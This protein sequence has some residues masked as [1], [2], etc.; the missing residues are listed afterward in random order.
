MKNSNTESTLFYSISN[1]EDFDAI[2][3]VGKGLASTQRVR[4]LKALSRRPM[5]LLELSILLNMPISSISFN[6][7]ILEEAKLIKI[8]YK[9]A[10]KGKMKLCSLMAT[11]VHIQTQK[12]E[13]N[14]NQP[15]VVEMPVGCYT[16]ADVTEAYLVGEE[17]FIFRST[18]GNRMLFTPNRFTGQLFSFAEGSVVYD[19]PNLCE[20]TSKPIVISFSMEFC[21]EAPYYR[22]D[23]PSDITIW[24][25]DVEIAT[26]TSPGDFGG[27]RGTYTPLFWLT[28]STQ[29]GLLY[30]FS[31]DSKG[32]Y[33]NGQ[34]IFNNVTIKDLHLENN[35]SIQLKIGIKDDAIH[36]GGI[37]IFGKHFGNFNQDIM[38][39]IE[40]DIKNDL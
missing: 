19:F 12:E 28:E 36:K 2:A 16:K 31:A 11:D 24:I 21:S 39:T 6:V 35:K 8:D 13:A 40:E 37:N 9:P 25:N 33:V 27:K 15:L 38:M 4:I 1:K 26:V 29:F 34:K 30:T 23:W 3:K 22:N 5:N 32:C 14:E 10:Q 18:V 17:G 20:E 7:D